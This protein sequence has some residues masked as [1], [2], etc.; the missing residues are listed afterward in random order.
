MSTQNRNKTRAK[1]SAP[2][3]ESQQ[4]QTSSKD[5]WNRV[6]DDV[7]SGY[8]NKNDKDGILNEDQMADD[9]ERGFGRLLYPPRAFF[10]LYGP[11]GAD[12]PASGFGF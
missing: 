10:P 4:E 7:A 6:A 1:K 3:L 2:P 9:H 5:Y 11:G 8:K 12:H